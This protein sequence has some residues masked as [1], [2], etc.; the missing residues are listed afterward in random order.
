[1]SLHY[2]VNVVTNSW[3]GILTTSWG[4]LGA[5]PTCFSAD[6]ASKVKAALLSTQQRCE[7]VKILF[8]TNILLKRVLGNCC[9]ESNHSNLHK[10]QSRWIHVLHPESS[11]LLIPAHL[12]T[13]RL[14]NPTALKI[15]E[16]WVDGGDPFPDLGSVSALHTSPPLNSDTWAAG[17]Y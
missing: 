3:V 7:N 15:E 14:L 13:R 1:M 5:S 16:R 11:G 2:W 8:H 10:Q 6:R 9:E 17:Y 4:V 12:V